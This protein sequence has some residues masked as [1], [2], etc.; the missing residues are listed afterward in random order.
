MRQLLCRV[1]KSSGHE[2]C[3]E[4]ILQHGRELELQFGGSA[5]DQISK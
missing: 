5:A 3:R 4:E 1:L 2:P